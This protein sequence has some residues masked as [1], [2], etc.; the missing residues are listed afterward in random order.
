VEG[1]DGVG[2]VGGRQSTLPPTFWPCLLSLGRFLPSYLKVFIIA[3]VA[4]SIMG[5]GYIKA[6]N[7]T[8]KLPPNINEAEELIGVQ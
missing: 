6:V 1:A 3:S 5:C 2:W 8:N 7:I 4:I